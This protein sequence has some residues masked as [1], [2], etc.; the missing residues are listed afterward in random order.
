VEA[1]EISRFV[2]QT[3]NLKPKLACEIT[4]TSSPYL[5]VN[6]TNFHMV[7]HIVYYNASCLHI[8]KSNLRIIN[9]HKGREI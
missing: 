9:V 1:L 4:G 7:Y 3:K 6:S 2:N 8:F 5:H